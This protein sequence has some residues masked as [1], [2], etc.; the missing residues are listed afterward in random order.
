MATSSRAASRPRALWLDVRFIIG[1]VLVVA[2]AIG[3]WAVVHAARTTR[4]VLV[5]AHAIVPGQTVTAAD[6]V[7]LDARLGD[8]EPKYLEPSALAEGMV[9]TRGIAEGELVPVAA[10]GSAD[11]VELTSLVVRSAFDVPAGVVAGS[12]VELWATPLTGPGEYG[13]PLVIVPHAVIAEVRVDDSM[14][15][16]AGADLEVVVARDDVE[17]VLEHVAG[18]SAMS[19]VPASVPRA[20]APAG[21]SPEPSASPSEDPS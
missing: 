8:A 20:A 6:L 12:A 15:S 5:A 21:S 4:P 9:A 13:E 14:V 2:S 18:G 11:D 19:A 3:V 17:I 10:I 16:R 1:I 7:E